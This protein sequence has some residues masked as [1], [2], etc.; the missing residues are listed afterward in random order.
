[1]YAARL[2]QYLASFDVFTVNA[3]QQRADVVPCHCLVEDLSEHFYARYD[4]LSRFILQTYDFRRVADFDGT[5]FYTARRYGTAAG[6]REYVFDRHQERFVRVAGRGRDVFVNCFHQVFD[7]LYVLRFAVQSA[8][9]GAYD[10]R[11]IIAGEAVFVQQITDFHFDKVDQFRI[12]YLVSFVQEYD[13]SRYADLLCQQDVFAG[14]RHRAVS[15]GYDEDSAVHLCRAGDH[16]LDIV[17]VPGAVYVR[18][19]AGFGFVF[20][21]SGVDGDAACSFFRSLV[22][23]CIV[24][25]VCHAFICQDFGDRRGQGRLAVV[26]VADGADVNM[27]LSSFVMCFCHFFSS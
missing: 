13:D 5:A 20:Y 25:E 21:G 24:K 26:D 17:G 18:I 27:R 15:C 9:R 10:D 23:G 16:V 22:D 2:R 19:V 1:M 7:C 11:S 12:I 6:D 3:A 14:L 8:Q 4:G